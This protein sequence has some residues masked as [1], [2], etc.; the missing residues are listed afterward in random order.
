MQFETIHPFLDGN[1]RVGRLLITLLFCVEKLLRDPLLYLSLYLKRHRNEYYRLLDTVRQ[2]GDWEKWIGFFADGVI[3]SSGGAVDTAQQLV[4]TAREDRDRIH[5][6]GRGA[7]TALR[8]HH[9]LQQQ[10]VSNSATI[11]ARTKI[12]LPSVLKS[13]D[14]LQK[15][16][17][18]KEV[19]GRKRSR[20]FSYAGYVKIL[21]E[22]T[23]PL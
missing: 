14:S 23:E 16:G 5:D 11:V 19:T 1:G 15:I 3:E 13:L 4:K 22:G 21:T 9:S 10:P 6:L 8:V 7:S 17:I 2:D 12:S 18:V 20:V